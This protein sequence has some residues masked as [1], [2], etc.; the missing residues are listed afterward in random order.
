M[1]G[2]EYTSESAIGAVKLPKISGQLT[3]RKMI[4]KCKDCKPHKF[5]DKRHGKNM[6]VMNACRLK[7]DGPGWYRCTVCG[8]E[9]HFGK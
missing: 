2:K 4:K 7:K 1:N 9:H 6:R 8:T 3:E 5:Q